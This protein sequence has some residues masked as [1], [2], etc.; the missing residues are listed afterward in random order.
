[1]H[2]LL[3]VKEVAQRLAISIS[4]VY[5][6]CAHGNL[7]HNRIGGAVRIGENDLAEFIRQTRVQDSPS[8]PAPMRR[9]Q[10]KHFNL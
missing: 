10:S 1:M 3:T 7:P 5:E 2:Q 8:T 4:K 6:L 9:K